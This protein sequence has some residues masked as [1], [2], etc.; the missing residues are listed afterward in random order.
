MSA[1]MHAIATAAAVDVPRLEAAY[2]ELLLAIGEDPDRDGLRDTPR[3]AAATWTEFLG[4]DHPDRLAATFTHH[5]NGNSSVL[6]RGIDCWSV[7]EHHLLPFRLTLAVAYLPTAGLVLG[8]SKLARIVAHH[9]GRL[10]LQ[11]RLCDAVADD[12]IVYSG[13]PDV[14]VWAEGEH[15]CMSL[16]GIRATTA[17]TVTETLRGRL[18]AD[19][20]LTARLITAAG[21]GRTAP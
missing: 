3:R 6:V 13:S 14:A 19:T 2:R 7:C 17:R 4:A 12:L 21:I 8:L 18:A 11:E 16:R 15:L 20:A 10:Q 1:T 5:T 9:A